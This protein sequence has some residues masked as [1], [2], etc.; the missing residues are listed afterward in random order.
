VWSFVQKV[1]PVVK[2]LRSLPLK[3]NAVWEKNKIKT[4]S[5]KKNYRKGTSVHN[6]VL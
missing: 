2:L 1:Q 6:M 4:G 5:L 3:R